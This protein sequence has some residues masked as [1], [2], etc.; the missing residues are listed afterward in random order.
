MTAFPYLGRRRDKQ[1][2]L[3]PPLSHLS[4][5]FQAHGHWDTTALLSAFVLTCLDYFQRKGNLTWPPRA[6]HLPPS[7]HN[8]PPPT[9]CTCVTH[10]GTASLK[11]MS[12]LCSKFC[13][14][15][16]A[17]RIVPNL[18]A[19]CSKIHSSLQAYLP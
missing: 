19:S 10:N 16:P 9:P 17:W 11:F 6:G 13:Q 5:P 14:H 18:S 12:F 15:P 8:L 4:P 3:Q 2:L 1:K 7:I